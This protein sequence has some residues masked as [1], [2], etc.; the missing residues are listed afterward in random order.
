MQIFLLC[1]FQKYLGKTMVKQC[2][3]QTYYLKGDK[4]IFDRRIKFVFKYALYKLNFVF[5]CAFF[6]K[7]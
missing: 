2:A 4:F 6:S 3:F 1:I 7:L 5:H